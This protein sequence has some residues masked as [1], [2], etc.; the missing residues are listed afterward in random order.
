VRR[1]EKMG[2][3]SWDELIRE[4]DRVIDQA[5]AEQRA[6]ESACTCG[7]VDVVGASH[8]DWCEIKAQERQSS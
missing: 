3:K 1:K 2:E 6:C 7:A 8:L 4:S 5:M